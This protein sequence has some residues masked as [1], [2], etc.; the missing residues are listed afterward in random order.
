MI[1]RMNNDEVHPVIGK[2]Y[3]NDTLYCVPGVSAGHFTPTTIYH[4]VINTSSIAGGINCIQNHSNV[5]KISVFFNFPIIS[6][7]LS[8]AF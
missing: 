8:N 2:L 7:N 1:Q 4:L 6:S 5:L 3:L